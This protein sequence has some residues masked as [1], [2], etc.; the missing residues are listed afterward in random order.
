[1]GDVEILDGSSVWFGAVVRG[2]VA[3]IRIG[4][5]TNVQD[6]CVIHGTYQKHSTHIGSRVTIG[7]LAML[8]GCWIGDGSLIGMQS[9]IMDGVKIGSHCIVGA[10]SLVVE[11]SEFPDDSLI[12]GSPAKVKRKLTKTEIEFLEKS[13]DN[14]LEY[15]RWYR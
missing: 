12:L 14:Y 3:S 7:H 1:V 6:G 9:T 5:Q 8:H 13:A 11:G 2:D 15:S 10:Q 4:K